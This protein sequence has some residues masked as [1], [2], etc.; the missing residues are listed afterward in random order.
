M[1]LVDFRADN[2]RCLERV[3]LVADPRAN[4]IYG[5]NGSGKTSIL[6]AIGFLSRGRSFRRAPAGSVVRRGEKQFIVFGT[7][8]SGN[9]RFSIGVGGRASGVDVRIDRADAGLADL[10]TAL[11]L[12]VI[13]PDVHELVAGGPEARRK[14]LDWIGFHVEHDFLADWRRFRQ[15]LKQRNS[16]LKNGAGISAW[17]AEFVQLGV[18]LDEHRRS[19]MRAAIEPIEKYSAELLG[20]GLAFEYHPGWSESKTL[21]AAVEESLDRDLLFGSTQVGPH[22]G[23]LRLIASDRDAKRFVSRG[24]QKL[25]ACALILAA[26]EVVQGRSGRRM[27]L[28]IDDPSAELDRGSS[29]RLMGAVLALDC[30]VFATA[31]ERNAL[32]LPEAAAVFHVEHGALA[33]E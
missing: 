6:E 5:R 30:Q 33:P 7:V 20:T 19:A 12:Q 16:A 9:R 15:A 25:L 22:R 23:D 13:D 3:S 17:T 2:F 4:L 8:E 18:R 10:A 27:T 11:P 29:T 1:P 26:T 28:L 32:E 31:L 14:F 24:Q 21:A